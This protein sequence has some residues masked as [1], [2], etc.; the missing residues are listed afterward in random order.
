MWDFMLD[1]VFPSFI[2]ICAIIITIVLGFLAKEMLTNP[3][4]IT[5]CKC[6]VERTIEHARM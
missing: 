2:I 3:D 4:S 1:Y 5:G 6:V